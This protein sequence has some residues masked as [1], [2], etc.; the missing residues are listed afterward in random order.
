MPI[1]RPH[2]GVVEGCLH[3]A[4][5]DWEAT[6]EF[7]TTNGH[8]ISPSARARIIYDLVC[9]HARRAFMDVPGVRVG[10]DRGFLTIIF[11][12]ELVLRFKKLK[13]N[14]EWSGIP[15]RQQQLFESQEEIPG[16]PSRATFL[17]AGYVLDATGTQVVRLV[18]SCRDETRLLWSHEL[19]PPLGT[20]SSRIYSMPSPTHA[21]A[22]QQLRSKI[23][24]EDSKEAD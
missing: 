11:G 13:P 6:R 15:T 9:H 2:L 22:P 5:K 17:V 21:P 16:L 23:R 12:S 4:W 7:H 10:S 24:K 8:P 18:I 19:E 3:S 14:L 20:V 1:L